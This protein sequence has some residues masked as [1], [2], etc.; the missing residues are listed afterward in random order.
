MQLLE[1]NEKVFKKNLLC[2][3]FQPIL[4][5]A[6]TKILKGKPKTKAAYH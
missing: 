3:T 1:K 5:T 2:Q 4:W 6:L